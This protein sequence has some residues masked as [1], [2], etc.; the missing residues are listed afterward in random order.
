M[1]NSSHVLQE[2]NGIYANDE[3]QHY[4][5]KKKRFV[6]VTS[7]LKKCYLIALKEENSRTQCSLNEK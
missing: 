1:E 3:L 7:T 6:N 2:F 5:L 4:D